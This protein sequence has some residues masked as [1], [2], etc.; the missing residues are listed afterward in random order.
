MAQRVAVAGCRL[1]GQGDLSASWTDRRGRAHVDRMPVGAADVGAGPE[2]G[3][4]RIPL[5][6]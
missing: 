3:C 2:F 5:R 1:V 6:A 4:V